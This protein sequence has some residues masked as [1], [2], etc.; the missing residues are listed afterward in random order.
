MSNEKTMHVWLS[1]R[2]PED[3]AHTLLELDKQVQAANTVHTTIMDCLSP[4]ILNEGFSLV[5]HPYKGNKFT[6]LREDMTPSGKAIKN[7]TNL[8]GMIMKGEYND[9]TRTCIAPT[10]LN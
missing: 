4:K 9:D 2:Y 3:A 7:G 5:V 6:I 10:I 8:K 1:N